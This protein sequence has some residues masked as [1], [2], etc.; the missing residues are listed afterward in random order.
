MIRKIRTQAEN[1]TTHQAQLV[2]AAAVCKINVRAPYLAV[3]GACA[4]QRVAAAPQFSDKS[5]SEPLSCDRG[6]DS[7]TGRCRGRGGG[8]G[9]DFLL[10]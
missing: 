2:G 7:G 5:L 4:D 10:H 8:R 9:R 1:P 6:G 3:V